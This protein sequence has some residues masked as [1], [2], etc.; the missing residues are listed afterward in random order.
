MKEV[1]YGK[2]FWNNGINLQRAFEKKKIA[3][4]DCL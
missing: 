4:N 2:C 1:S 3:Y